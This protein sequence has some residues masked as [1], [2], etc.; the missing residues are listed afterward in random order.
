[1]TFDLLPTVFLLRILGGLALLVLLL[2]VA[3]LGETWY[4]RLK[5]GAC[6]AAQDSRAPLPKA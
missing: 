2:A 3:W 4:T 6:A 5:Q 1:M